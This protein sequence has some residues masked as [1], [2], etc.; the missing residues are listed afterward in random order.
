[1]NSEIMNKIL[2]VCHMS[3]LKDIFFATYSRILSIAVILLVSSPF[4]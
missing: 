1:M 3:R 2:K 4:L